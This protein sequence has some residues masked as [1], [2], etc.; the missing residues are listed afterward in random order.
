[1]MYRV[2]IIEDEAIIRKGLR[3]AIDWDTLKCTVVGEAANGNEGYRL[4]EKEKPDIIVLDINMPIMDGI[5]LLELL[6]RETYSVIIISGHSEFD[7]AKKAIEFGVTEYLLKPLDHVALTHSIQR[8]ISEIHMRRAYAKGA[9]E[10]ADIYCV[11]QQ[12]PVVASVTIMKALEYIQQHYHEKITL[13]DIRIYTGKSA[14]S[15]NNRFQKFIG[16]TFNEYLT[17]F[18][19][20]QAL[21]L[22]KTQSYHMYEIADMVGFSDYKYF[23]QV[24]HK[25]VGVAPNIVKTYYSRT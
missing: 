21:D 14:T 17:K 2:C 22:I 9:K 8:A 24:F 23:N 6:P 20:Q 19:I 10:V 4:I 12:T 13:E 11:L 5:A 7:Y 25:V 16:M 1:M 3:R 15:I 18:R